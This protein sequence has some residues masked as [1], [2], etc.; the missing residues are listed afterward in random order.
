MPPVGIALLAVASVAIDWALWS[1]GPNLQTPFGAGALGCMLGQLAVLCMWITPSESF[2]VGRLTGITRATVTL[3]VVIGMGWLVARNDPRYDWPHTIALLG[4]YCAFLIALR[5][6]FVR[7]LWDKLRFRLSDAFGWST[8]LAV[9][10]AWSR[11]AL[12]D[13]AILDTVSF[14]I[15]AGLA[16]L[17]WAAVLEASRPDGRMLYYGICGLAASTLL[18]QS[19]VLPDHRLLTAALGQVVTLLIGVGVVRVY[20]PRRETPRRTSRSVSPVL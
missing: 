10:L 15:S 1:T 4:S 2:P 17:G 19:F 11:T 9:W 13:E 5:A 7:E 16:A 8:I 20:Q 3:V 14:S 6:F 18:V 12:A